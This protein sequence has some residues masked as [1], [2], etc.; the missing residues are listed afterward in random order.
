MLRELAGS[1]RALEVNTVLPLPADVVR[2]WRDEGGRAVTFG[3][4]AHEP[5]ALARGFAAA[6]DLV[7]ACGFRPG[8]DP[9]EPWRR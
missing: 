7:R 1:G 6:A 4:D 5:P 3:S 9:W 8:R 2:W